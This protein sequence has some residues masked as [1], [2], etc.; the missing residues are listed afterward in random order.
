MDLWSVIDNNNERILTVHHPRNN[1]LQVRLTAEAVFDTIKENAFTKTLYPLIMVIR[2]RADESAQ[3]LL[4]RLLMDTFGELLCHGADCPAEPTP[5]NLSNKILLEISGRSQEDFSLGSQPGL[6]IATPLIKRLSNLNFFTPEIVTG[7]PQGKD[8]LELSVMPETVASRVATSNAELLVQAGETQ[9]IRVEPNDSRVDC[10]NYN[11]L[12]VWNMGVQMAALH[13]QTPGLMMDLNEGMFAAN[14]GCGYALKPSI[15]IDS[16]ITYDSAGKLQPNSV[17][18][19]NQHEVTTLHLRIISGT[20][21]PK[22]RGAGSKGL[23]I[24]PYVLIEVFGAA[25]DCAEHRTR[26]VHNCG[27]NPV[28]DESC[29]FRL[30]VPDMALIR[31]VILDD[32]FIGDEFIGQYT[33]AHSCLL[34]GYRV[35][36]LHGIFGEELP[37][38]SLL[39]HIAISSSRETSRKKTMLR[40]RPSRVVR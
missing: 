12:D 34:P 25:A 3:H 16:D 11:P 1:R 18:N 30:T 33:I 38:A 24:D 22:P 28:F 14:G 26:T 31:F 17:I 13:F 7:I 37:G 21:L 8:Q 23:V 10:S 15:M 2:V 35:L 29:E 20:D 27:R 39:V 9:L 19:R 6:P 4:V 5:N 36:K 40:R 32:D